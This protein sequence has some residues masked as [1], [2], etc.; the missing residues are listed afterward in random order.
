MATRTIESMAREAAE[1]CGW[2]DVAVIEVLADFIDEYADTDEFADFLRARVDEA[3]AGAPG[4]RQ[5]GEEEES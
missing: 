1:Q 2:D 3:L 5:G 4:R